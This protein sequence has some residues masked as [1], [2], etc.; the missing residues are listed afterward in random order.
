MFDE[1]SVY[2]IGEKM[3]NA[4]FVSWKKIGWAYLRNIN[5]DR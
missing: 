5:V 2:R 3:K 1:S 4:F